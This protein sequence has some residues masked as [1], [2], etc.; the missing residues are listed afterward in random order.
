MKQV[1]QKILL[2]VTADVSIG[3]L[4]GFPGHLATRGWD[5]HVVSS[6]GPRSEQLKSVPGVTVHK[7]AMRREPSPIHDL[8][9]LCSW[10]AL[11]R[12]V[13]PDVLSVGTPKAGLLGGI[14]GVLTSVRS[15][16]YMLRGLRY[17]TTGGLRRLI[18]VNLE[19]VSVLCAHRSIAVSHTL[20]DVAVADRLG[21]AE[22]FCV[23]GS[24]S[25]NGVEADRFETSD[26]ERVAAKAA[27]W[28]DDPALP[29]VVFIGRIHPDKGLD[30]LADA[31]DLL[32]ERGVRGRLVIVGGSDDPTGAALEARL[33][34]LEW[35][36][37]MPGAVSD[38]A[39]FLRAADM[40]CLP[41]RREGFPNVVLEAAAAGLPTVATLATGVPDAVVDGTT[42][43][44]CSTREP[45][46]LAAA[47]ESLIVDGDLR[48]RLGAAAHERVRAEFTNQ[49][50]WDSL[51][52]RYLLPARSPGSGRT[53]SSDS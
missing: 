19:R 22:K 51:E 3:L 42:G 48:R 17:E 34:G 38:V 14:A 41:T 1:R 5:V 49:V 6:G 33:R 40:L 20:R 15:R 44:V 52:A 4:G 29:T 7:I 25:S 12:E 32:V 43:I 30:L 50:V 39:P 16:F 35:D 27:L 26:A 23:V 31:V 11:L 21:P 10:V 18:F 47:L 37:A 46:P 28:P 36:V 53:E 24:G 45:A 8:R 13:R 2:G 9:A